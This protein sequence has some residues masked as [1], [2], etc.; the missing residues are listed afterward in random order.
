M[1]TFVGDVIKMKISVIMPVN[2]SGEYYKEAMESLFAQTFREF[3]IICV[4]DCS[5]DIYTKTLLLKLSF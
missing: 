1:C 3:E 2:N 4:D 5:E